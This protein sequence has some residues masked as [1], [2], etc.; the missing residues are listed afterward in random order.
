[1]N[2]RID[3]LEDKLRKLEDEIYILRRQLEERNQSVKQPSYPLNQILPF[4]V[5]L[6][7]TLSTLLGVNIQVTSDSGESMYNDNVPSQQN[8]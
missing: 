3:I 5:P 1:M 7:M 2:R 6:A 8:E 4:A